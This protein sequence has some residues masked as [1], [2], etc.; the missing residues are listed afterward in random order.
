MKAQHDLVSSFF[1]FL[2]T[3]CQSFSASI[4]LTTTVAGAERGGSF[5]KALPQLLEL[6][7]KHLQLT[8][9]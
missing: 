3:S 6:C 8:Q 9:T 7:P 4:E 5:L 2:R 1:F